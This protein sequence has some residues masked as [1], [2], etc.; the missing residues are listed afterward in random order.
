M[1]E[2]QTSLPNARSRLGG[3]HDLLA[4]EYGAI[5]RAGINAQLDDWYSS[6]TGIAALLG[7]E[8]MGKSW[9]ALDWH[10][11]LKSSATGAPLTVFLP[12]TSV[13]GQNIKA[14]IA[15]ALADQTQLANVEFWEKRLGLWERAGGERVRILIL[16]DGL[17]ENFSFLDWASWL[18]PLFEDRLGSMY[19]VIVSCW[20]NWWKDSLYR[21]A[22]LA[23]SPREIIVEGFND[24]ELNSLLAAMQ[25]DPADLTAGVRK[26]MRVPRLSS[27]VVKHRKRLE[28]IS[29]VTA[30]RVVY[31]DWKDR[32]ERRGTGT[33]LSDLEMREFVAALGQELQQQINRPLARREV[34]E[35]LSERSGRSGL[36]LQ[37]AVTE[38]S[39]GAWLV[40]GEQANTFKVAPERIPFVL[41]AA[42]VAQLRNKNAPAEA[43]TGIAEFMDP[44]K[45]HRLGSAILRSAT[46]IAL[47]DEQT[48][49][50]LRQTLLSRWMDERHFGPGDF[51]DFWRLA[52]LDPYLILDVAEAHWLARSTDPRKDEVLIKSC[53]NAAEFDGFATVL[54]ERL[55]MWLGTA[56]PDPMVGAVLGD[57]DLTQPESLE[58]AAAT[59]SCYA[60]WTSTD[61]ASLFSPVRLDDHEGWSWLTAR[62]L[63]ILSYIRRAEFAC[64]LEAW[65]LSRAVMQRARHADEVAWLLRFNLEDADETDMTVRNLIARLEDQ[66]HTIAHKAAEFLRSA[67][68]HVDRASEPLAI[69]QGSERAPAE[70]HVEALSADEFRSAVRRCLSPSGG[71]EY[72]AVGSACLINSL[73]ERGLEENEGRLGE[74]LGNLRDLLI[75]LTP[76]NREQL[77]QLIE[78]AKQKSQGEADA[79]ERVSADLQLAALPLQLYGAEP[80]TQSSLVLESGVVEFPEKWLGL[81][82]PVAL[83]DIA[84]CGHENAPPEQL[85]R[86]LGYLCERLRQEE[87]E[88][89]SWLPNLV[90]HENQDV[91]HYALVLATLGRHQSALATFAASRHASPPDSGSDS[92]PNQEY[93]RNRALLESCDY[94]P[95]GDVIGNLSPE[96]IALIA[97]HRPNDAAARQG[98]HAYWRGEFEAIKS[99]TSWSC[100]RYWQSYEN[101]I[102]AVIEHDLDK[103]LRWL[104]PWLEDPKGI[105]EKPLMNRFP[106]IDTML[107]LREKAPEVALALY[108]AIMEQSQGMIWSTDGVIAFPFQVGNSPTAAARCERLLREAKSD[109]VLFIFAVAAH[110]DCQEDRLFHWIE[111]LNA[112]SLPADVAKAFTLLGFCDTSASADA[113]W[114]R[115]LASPPIDPWLSRVLQES[116]FDYERN[117]KARRAFGRFLSSDSPAAA[118]FALMQFVGSCDARHHL[119]SWNFGPEWE[120]WSYDCRVAYCLARNS[121]K[122]RLNE[123]KKQRKKRLF[124]TPPA[125]SNM[126]PWR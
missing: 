105:H 93:W 94:S 103:V 99:G 101:E 113:M 108:D 7:D 4:S 40:A 39:S 9:A 98:F 85:A 68:S 31:E 41:G 86:W 54:K 57:I 84:D 64:V 32:I 17:N 60:A 45:A 20:P 55:T 56:S 89:L 49:P 2:A 50:A 67:A 35:K 18:Q 24:A 30:E 96:H 119:P 91:R 121:L 97:K 124:H 109:Q 26:L 51:E 44:L 71:E 52:G 14:R 122:R 8:G 80:A 125:F 37:P 95:D 100:P 73:I 92:K 10:A 21:L 27:L 19:R 25:V 88:H 118:R 58:R 110:S 29:D 115:F 111:E 107:A 75:V 120:D 83:Q 112:S 36:E 78:V 102:E 74:V 3:H 34:L 43:E 11:S 15:K 117:R 63:A 53:A 5:S 79:S 70:M 72:G 77:L 47:L 23:P 116:A 38:L 76:P 82:Q 42:L 13:G 87:I 123:Q 81:L 28:G 106:V 48:P 65:A 104:E 46:T 126:A 61:A 66:E 12:A 62:A 90:R 6:D 69:S 16:L 22:N 1:H 114:K 33:G 59:R